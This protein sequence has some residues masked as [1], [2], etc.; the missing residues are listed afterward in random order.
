MW[1]TSF[2]LMQVLPHGL[3]L[4]QC[5]TAPVDRVVVAPVG[6]VVREVVA[7]LFVVAPVEVDVRA[8]VVTLFVVAPAGVDACEVVVTL[9]VVARAF[10]GTEAGA[11]VAAGA[12]ATHFV[13][14]PLASRHWAAFAS[15]LVLAAAKA[16]I[17]AEMP[18][19][20]VRMAFSSRGERS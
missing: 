4:L 12:D 13:K 15:T 20:I 10:G 17:A 1:Q 6:D 7:K 11:G 5:F 19:M 8:D 9:F 3:P 14:W 16:M 18:K 2:T